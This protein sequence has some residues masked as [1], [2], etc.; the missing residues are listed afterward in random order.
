MPLTLLGLHLQGEYETKSCTRLRAN[1]P[2]NVTSKLSSLLRTEDNR[3]VRLQG[4]RPLAASM[5][6]YPKITKHLHP[7][8]VR[9]LQSLRP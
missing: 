8:D 1:C 6:D 5:N 9:P 4:V 7:R 2:H 3:V